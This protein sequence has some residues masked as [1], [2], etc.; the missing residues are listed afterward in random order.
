MNTYYPRGCLDMSATTGQVHT[1]AERA[2]VPHVSGCPICCKTIIRLLPSLLDTG[3]LDKPPVQTPANP[4]KP[5]QTYESRMRALYSI[6]ST[7]SI[8]TIQEVPSGYSTM[9]A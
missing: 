8:P 1:C 2:R 9:H 4:H 6:L 7:S 3:K 5:R